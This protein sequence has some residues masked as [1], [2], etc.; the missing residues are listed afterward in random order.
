MKNIKSVFFSVIVFLLSVTT[1]QAQDVNSALKYNDYLASTNDTL[2]TLGSNWGKRF[3]EIREKREF[4]K[5][6][7]IRKEI[8]NYITRKKM[9]IFL[10]K[11]H[12]GS[13]KLRLAMIEF[14][15]F[16]DYMIGQGFLPFENL[17]KTISDDELEK[18][19]DKLSTLAEGEGDMLQKVIKEQ[20]VYAAKNGFK[21]E[22]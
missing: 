10:M 11:D 13:E 8:Q 16:Q 18:S 19:T 15:C 20:E 3:S 2:Y 7:P 17:S 5:L 4:E 14:L 1:L 21:M 22:D 9:E 6:T 12:K